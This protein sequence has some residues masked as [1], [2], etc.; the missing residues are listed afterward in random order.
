[1]ARTWLYRIATNE[2][3]T[4]LRRRSKSPDSVHLYEDDMATTPDSAPAVQRRL[5]VHTS[6][7]QLRPEQRVILVLR[8]W[9][10]LSYDEISA[11]LAISM[12]C[13]KMR[14]SR[15]RTEFR[16]VYGEEP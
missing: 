10:G 6:L 5:A 11:V 3:I 16:R 1:M 9:E 12:P 13:V 8:Y 14:L 4:M 7:N 15:A 2:A